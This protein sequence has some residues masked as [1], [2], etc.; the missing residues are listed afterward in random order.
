M[1]NLS[2]PVFDYSL[3]I[4]YYINVIHIKRK[5]FFDYFFLIMFSF[6]S[7]KIPQVTLF[8]TSIQ[9]VWLLTNGTLMKDCT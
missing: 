6:F 1:R 3:Q 5:A 2:R 9:T 8:T 4:N 7:A